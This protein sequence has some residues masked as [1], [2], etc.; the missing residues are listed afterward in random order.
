MIE[1]KTRVTNRNEILTKV[2]GNTRRE[3]RPV[4]KHQAALL[5]VGAPHG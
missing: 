3:R 1:E 4:K 5:A 2:R